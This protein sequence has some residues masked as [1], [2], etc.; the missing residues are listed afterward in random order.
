MDYDNLL[1]PEQLLPVKD[2][3]GAVLV[4]AGAGSGKT[5]VLTYRIAYLIEQLHVE[6]YNILA[7]TFTNKASKEMLERVQKVCNTQNVWI[8]TFHSFCARILRYDIDR[9]GYNKNFSIYTT[10]DTEKA[11]KR[12]ITENQLEEISKGVE[13]KWHI[14]NAK[15]GGK[16]P[17]KYR[18]TSDDINIDLICKVYRLYEEEL[19]RNNALDFDDLLLK[20]ILLF[21]NAPEVL[22]KWQERF[23]YIHIDEFQDTNGL[24]MLLAR[25]L[26]L[27]YGNIFVV[28]D[29]DQSIYGWRGAEVDNILNLNKF[30]PGVK[31]YK[32]QQNYRSTQNILDVANKIIANNHTR[33]GKELWTASGV[34]CNV[35]YKNCYNDTDEVEFCLREIQSLNRYNGYTYNDFAILV[36]LNSLT[37]KLED[38]CGLYSVPYRIYGGFKFYQRK[39]ILDTIAYMRILANPRDDVAVL[40]V[41]NFPKRGIGDTTIDKLSVNA[42]DKGITLAD[43]ILTADTLNSLNNGT[44][45]K[46]ESFAN[47][48]RRLKVAK[49]C[50]NLHDLAGAIVDISG[51]KAAFDSSDEDDSERIANI[52]QLI[53]N[54]QQFATN[55]PEYGIDEYLQSVSLISDSDADTDDDRIT[56]ATIH[57]VKGLEYKCVFVI[58]CEE[59]IFPSSRALNSNK[60]MEEERRCMYVA[61]T[62]ARERLYLTSAQSRFRFGKV[63]YYM[64]SRFVKESGLIKEIPQEDTPKYNLF[65]N[66]AAAVNPFANSSY[67]KSIATLEKDISAFKSGVKVNHRRYGEG[68][69]ISVDKDNAKIE[70]KGLGVKDFNLKL[71]PLEIIK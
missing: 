32:L 35:V 48:I 15:N 33:M 28:G 19:G 29:D 56:I 21:R 6:P 57:S 49:D 39:E 50:M 59:G 64:V 9:L 63:E 26:A 30:F 54:I 65:N 20:T 8:S 16:S 41:I 4:L 12:I 34:G 5:R 31:I 14:S 10:A 17:E 47:V 53:A 60:E 67:G 27:K 38:K 1:N 46:V 69:I 52:D 68:L 36:R 13:Y 43:M 25:M 66:T 24:Q 22:L 42:K 71:A 7:I 55:N 45:A 44:K 11:I 3:E 2:T 23:K 40:R 62:R 18:E 51:M 70:F 61:A 37:A 58:G